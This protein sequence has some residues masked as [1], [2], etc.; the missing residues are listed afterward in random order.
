[1][2]KRFLCVLLVLAMLLGGCS[3]NGGSAMEEALA[4]RA[5]V[6]SAGGCSF[7]AEVTADYGEEVYTFSLSCDTDGD[8]N[9][10]FT[11]TAP[12]SISGITG[13]VSGDTGN[14]TFDDK[15]L[16]FDPMAEGQI[17]PAAAAHTAAQSWR[18]GYI[19]TCG[20]ENG[21]LVL[22]VETSF[23]EEP[24]A[25]DTWIDEEKGVPLFSE[26]CYNGRKL[27]SVAFTDFKFS[28]KA[29]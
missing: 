29:E 16:A 3:L 5:K 28:S 19:A 27:L 25:V 2:A 23:Q 13:T 15:V 14:L 12:D 17:S 8:G 4:F 20:R 18:T 9:L 26:I 7:L 11:V 10:S 1:M 6:L 22:S 21:Q 24:L